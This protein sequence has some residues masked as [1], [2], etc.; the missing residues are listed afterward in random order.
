M[1][2]VGTWHIYEMESWDEDY[3]NMEVQA[4]ITINKNGHGDFQFG[5]DEGSL[6]YEV[7][8]KRLDFSFEG[9]DENDPCSGRGYLESPSKGVLRGKFYIHS[10]ES[11]FFFARR[12][13]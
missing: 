7:E 6:D 5:L 11:S 3:F 13:K 10:G 2:F 8:S 4:Y 1:S 12:Q 9:M